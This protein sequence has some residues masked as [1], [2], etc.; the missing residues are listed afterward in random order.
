MRMVF[1]LFLML[2]VGVLAQEE[3]EPEQ[4]AQEPAAQ[5]TEDQKNTRAVSMED[6][7]AADEK[8]NSEREALSKREQRINMLLEDL[9][10]QTRAIDTKEASIKKMLEDLR[11]NTIQDTIPDVQVAHWEARDPTIAARDFVLLYK[12]EPSV[13]VALV[14]KMKKKK[15]AKLIDAVSQL[16]ENGKKVAAK[17]H[18]AIGTGLLQAEN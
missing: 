5:E 13:A 9:G 3:Q 12:E 4:P 7:A 8:I 6:L 10:N 1:F 16:D 15:S 2:G 11:N 18:E 17:L 14:K